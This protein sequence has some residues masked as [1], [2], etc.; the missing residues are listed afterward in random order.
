MQQ[1][2]G[3]LSKTPQAS[4]STVGVL[5]YA[6]ILVKYRRLIIGFTLATT[7]ITVIYA[8]M[9]PNI[10][11]ART[12]I[13]PSDDDKPSVSAL[14]SQLGGLSGLAGGA[15][16]SKSTGDLYVTMLKSETVQ[17]PIIDRF[18]L[19]DLYKAKFRGD[20]YRMLGDNSVISLG[21]NDGVITIEV[22][23]KDPKLAADLA[24]AYVEELGRLAAGLNMN[25]A[26][27]NRLFLEKRIAET[28]ADLS[29]A[30][31]A[32]KDFQSRNKSISVTDQAKATIEGLAQLRAQLAAQEVQLST[33]RTQFSESSQEVKTAK[34]MVANLR[35]QI[36]KLEGAGGKSSSIPNVGNVPQLGQ[37]YLR[38]MRDFKIQEAVLEM[39]TKQNEATKLGE[40]KDITPFQVLQKAKVPDRKSKPARAKILQLVI[41]VSLL[42][43]FAVVIVLE[44]VERMDEKTREGWKELFKLK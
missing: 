42:V 32:L 30:E 17:D 15:I 33:Y 25:G 22:D 12:M 20:A 5:D 40:V 24:N 28:R 34:T 43:V 35:T 11:T 38:L 19:V 18:K 27:R 4:V 7:I 2:A 31:D 14:M 21:K 41:L 6:A 26:G 37:V 13:I 23:D 29:R 9:L 16:S 10:Y 39:L 3:Q 1:S 36:G 44:N 8:L